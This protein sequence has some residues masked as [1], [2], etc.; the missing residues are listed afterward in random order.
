MTAAVLVS[1]VEFGF[2]PSGTVSSLRDLGNWK[3]RADAIEHLRRLVT[4]LPNANAVLPSLHAFAVFLNTLLEDPNFKISL[5]TLQIWDALLVKV[6]AHASPVVG[7]IVKTLVKKLGDNKHVVR[8]ANM[9][10]VATLYKTLPRETVEALFSAFDDPRTAGGPATARFKEDALCALTRLMLDDKHFPHKQVDPARLVAWLVAAAQSGEVGG[11]PAGRDAWTTD[12]TRTRATAVEALALACDRYGKDEVW[13]LVGVAEGASVGGAACGAALRSTLQ[14]RFSDPRLP[15]TASDGL[16]VHCEGATI[17]LTMPRPEDALGRQLET[18]PLSVQSSR[19]ASRAGSRIESLGATTKPSGFHAS[20]LKMIGRSPRAPSATMPR[21]T[22]SLDSSEDTEAETETETPRRQ[23][24]AV[25]AT[26]LGRAAAAANAKMAATSTPRSGVVTDTTRKPQTG[27]GD[28][29]V[30]V[31]DEE[32][33]SPD[34]ATEKNRLALRRDGSDGSFGSQPRRAMS[35]TITGRR[36]SGP[37][38]GSPANSDAG[39]KLTALKQRRAGSREGSRRAREGSGGG[40]MRSTTDLEPAKTFA[41]GGVS[42]PNTFARR[43]N[44]ASPK[45]PATA[46]T[47]P[48]ARPSPSASRPARHSSQPL[49]SVTAKTKTSAQRRLPGSSGS[50][51]ISKDKGS[52]LRNS[53]VDQNVSPLDDPSTEEL[54]PCPDPELAAR[55]S[56]A[57]LAKAAAAK[58]MELD[59][60]EQYES[61]LELR[62]LVKHH[63]D[64]IKESLHQICAA[65]VPAVDSLRSQIAKIATQLVREML[66]FLDKSAVEAELGFLVPPLVKRAGE[67]TWLGDT[68]DELVGDFAKILSTTKVLSALVPHCFHKDPKVRSRVA[69][70]VEECCASADAK[71]FT[72]SPQTVLLLEKTFT[73][74]VPLLEDGSLET[75]TMAKRSLCHLAAVAGPGEFDR[76]LKKLGDAKSRVAAGKEF[77]HLPR[78]ASLIAHTRTRRD[79]FL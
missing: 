69:W 49:P 66:L 22:S 61:L 48:P 79:Y 55:A 6:G 23:P 2:V 18:L 27:G 54:L 70:H 19:A 13:R 77:S 65:L 53:L 5:T 72:G 21:S 30:S 71:T 43:Q 45:F 29:S 35:P 10:S 60:Q 25:T 26:S 58:P 64:A 47:P 9:R 46:T 28:T 34:S 68:A 20:L 14:R 76:L 41:P 33:E 8:Q 7:Q 75:R 63:P 38:P 67:N 32:C 56:L 17:V 16:I 31:S 52:S 40:L 3:S 51:D 78:S 62:R 44:V 12:L 15:R 39:V 73:G 11:G 59:W 4:D 1:R 57:G 37:P 50:G 24:R 74:V 42:T 36:P